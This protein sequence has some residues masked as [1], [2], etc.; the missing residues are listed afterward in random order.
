MGQ[1]KESDSVKSKE[2]DVLKYGKEFH[3]LVQA[4]WQSTAKGEISSEKLVRKPSGRHGRIDVHAAF[5]AGKSVTVLEI[6]AT[7]WDKISEQAVRRNV[8]RQACQVWKYIESQLIDGKTVSPGIAFPKRPESPD[9]LQTIETLFGEQGIA[10]VWYDESLEYRR[11]R[12]RAPE[13]L[14]TRQK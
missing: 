7:D 13:G 6:K 9:R 10:V 12:G 4:D 8:N 11:V 2:P 3:K 14:D 1:N 5:Q